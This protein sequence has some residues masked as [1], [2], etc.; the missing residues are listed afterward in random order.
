MTKIFLFM[1]ICSGIPGNE[2]IKIST[3]QFEFND[4][5][6]CTLYGYDH[7]SEII[8]SL[9]RKIVN[10]KEVFTKFV[11]QSQQIV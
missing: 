3:P 9:S 2:C 8:E 10:E 7:S 4:M 6:D 5:Y 1:W 11:C